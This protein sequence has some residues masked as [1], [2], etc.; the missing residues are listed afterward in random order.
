MQYHLFCGKDERGKCDDD[1][2]DGGTMMP[3]VP[4]SK[5][6]PAQ[7]RLMVY[8]QQPAAVAG[9]NTGK[10]FEQHLPNATNSVQ[11]TTPTSESNSLISALAFENAPASAAPWGNNVGGFAT[12]PTMSLPMNAGWFALAQ[13][14]VPTPVSSGSIVKSEPD[15]AQSS[16]RLASPD[17]SRAE[18]GSEKGAKRPKIEIPEE[19]FH[20]VLNIVPVLPGCVPCNILSPYLR[21]RAGL[22]G[23]AGNGAGGDGGGVRELRV[24]HPFDSRQQR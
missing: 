20:Q 3:A 19:G 24:S 15:L 14:P 13:V 2:D 17:V 1:D 9:G 7:S 4:V 18:G 21:F 8:S 6:Q 5:C 10:S 22:Q 12:S 11:I 16:K 23:E